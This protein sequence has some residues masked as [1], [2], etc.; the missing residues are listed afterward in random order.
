[1]SKGKSPGLDG[2][3]IEFYFTFWSDLGPLMLDMMQ[4]SIDQ[5]CF[6]QNMNM[7]IISLLLKRHKDSTLCSS[8]LPLSLIG[9]DIKIYAKVLAS[10]LEGF[11]TKLV[12]HDQ[13]GFIKSCSSSDNL[14]RLLHIIS[15]SDQLISPSAILSLDAMKAFDPLEWNYLWAVL[16]HLG[17]NYL[18]KYD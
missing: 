18:Y 8:Y 7:A 9:T 15:L 16:D 4:Y 10:R 3:P 2:I 12:N 17:F 13:T 14:R 1:M 11:M 6:S 5:G